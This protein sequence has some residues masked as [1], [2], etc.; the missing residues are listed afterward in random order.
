MNAH[1]T[2]ATW[3]ASLKHLLGDIP[4]PICKAL[5]A[6]SLG[7]A[8]GR[9]CHSSRIAACTP[10]AAA[11]ASSRRRLE[12][13]LANPRL[14]AEQVT[15]SLVRSLAAT[16]P[17]RHWVLIIDET[18]RDE[19]IRS[20]QVLLA[21]KHRAIPLAARAY[22]PSGGPGRLPRLLWRMLGLIRRNLPADTHVTVLADRGLAWPDLVRFCQRWGWHYVLRIQ[23]QTAVWPQEAATYRSAEAWLPRAREVPFCS[24]ARVFKVTG[25][26][27][28]HFTAIRLKDAK[29]PALLISDQPGAWRHYRRYGQ[30]SWCEEAFR[31][32]KSG[33][34]SWR[35]SHVDDP[36]H[37]TRLLVVMMLA[38]YLCLVLG[39]QI[40]KRGLRRQLDPHTSRLWS[41][42]KLGLCW[43]AHGFV[44]NQCT[45]LLP[46]PLVPV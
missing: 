23:G 9:H 22:R 19:Q 14:Q 3:L 26:L 15:A 18:D 35:Q 40:V 33:G 1:P 21:Y 11:P 6:L 36:A 31:D 42:F 39:S 2:V 44:S 7:M 43:L 25:W 5:A 12:R 28:C 30:R 46:V 41:Y 24:R 27:D 45:P 29:E 8:L 38:M 10:T 32:E 20:L 34:F 13:L 16:W 4:K 37:A 17:G